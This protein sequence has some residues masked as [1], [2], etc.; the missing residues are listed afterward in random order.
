MELDKSFAREIS[1]IADG[2]GSRERKF[3]FLS[4]CRAAAKH[5]STSHVFDEFNHAI[6]AYGRVAVAVC[7]AATIS[8]RSDRLLTS[9]VQWAHAV[10]KCWHNRPGNL[11]SIVI[12][13]NLHPTRIEEYAGALIRLTSTGI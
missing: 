13:D 1:R 10:L 4:M 3:E 2:D 9:N 5:L 7:V 11:N 6:K 12:M 8:K